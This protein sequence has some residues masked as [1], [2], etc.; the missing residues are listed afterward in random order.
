MRVLSPDAINEIK[1]DHTGLYVAA[2][3]IGAVLFFIILITFGVLRIVIEMAI[4]H[5]YYAFG[6]IAIFLFLKIRKRKK[7]AK[8]EMQYEY[9]NR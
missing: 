4:K 2:L 1:E 8:Q 5:Y 6:I 3:M 7:K 9:P